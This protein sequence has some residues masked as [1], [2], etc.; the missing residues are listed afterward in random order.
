MFLIQKLTLLL[1]SFY[2]H[3]NNNITLVKDLKMKNN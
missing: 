1:H 2:G 3:A